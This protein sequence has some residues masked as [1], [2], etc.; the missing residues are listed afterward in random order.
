[1]KIH[2]KIPIVFFQ[3]MLVL[4]LLV[5]TPTAV[6]ADQFDAGV[7][8]YKAGNYKK[9]FELFKPLAEQGEAKV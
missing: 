6:K 8:A 4:V 2:L 9:A 1:M 7:V 3:L 5:G